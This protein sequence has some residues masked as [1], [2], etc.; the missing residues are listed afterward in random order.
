MPVVY[1]LH[2]R[3][4]NE[5]LPMQPY[6]TFLHAILESPEDDTSRLVFADWL[7]ENGGAVWAA[8]AELI[9][10]GVKLANW[11][12]LFDLKEPPVDVYA[13]ETE[14]IIGKR[15]IE[16]ILKQYGTAFLPRPLRAGYPFARTEGNVMHL[17]NFHGSV[18]FERGW[19]ARCA[20][21]LPWRADDRPTAFERFAG[22]LRALLT[23][24]PLEECRITVEG[25][26]PEL[27]LTFGP[28][29][30]AA[31]DG[32]WSAVLVDAEDSDVATDAL[33]KPT[34]RELLADL[35]GWLTP[36]LIATDFE[37]ATDD[38]SDD[39]FEEVFGPLDGDYPNTDF[40]S[41]DIPF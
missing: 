11:R 30:R 27:V 26:E 38:V 33:I 20:V 19:I 22:H 41:L 25:C 13:H 31:P 16:S 18:A 4:T 14:P 35:P 39:D 29:I 1:R 7:D 5:K 32:Y 34:R 15:H 2:V 17:D 37:R 12:S 6:A 8:R 24:N 10:R 9:R 23:T 40:T 21:E 36:H 28:D 3:N